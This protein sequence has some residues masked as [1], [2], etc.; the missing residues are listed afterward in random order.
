MNRFL[1]AVVVG[2]FTLL[3]SVSAYA[4]HPLITDDTGTQGKGKFQLEVNGTY[5]RNSADGIVEK[6][7]DLGATLTYG[8]IDNLDISLGLPYQYLSVK[9]DGIS[10]H[11]SGLS[12]VEINLKWRF[13]ETEG[14]SFALKPGVTLPTGDEDRGLGAGRATYSLFF[15]TTKELKPLTFHLNLGYIRNESKFDEQ[16]DIWH[17]SLASEIG[18][19][20]DLRLVSNIG[21]ER[22]PEKDSGIH[23]AFFLVGLIYGVAENFDIDAGL[24]VGLNKAEAD[25]QILAGITYRF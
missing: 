25:Y 5:S 17:A 15:I 12:D 8:L 7:T 2:V 1:H 13:Y 9:A 6:V 11:E 10:A 18:L 4:A 19:A 21:I 24:K 23:P 16:K 22:T 20:K 3:V 14:L